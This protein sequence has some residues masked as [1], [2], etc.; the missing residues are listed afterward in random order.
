MKKIAIILLIILLI[1]LT[2]CTPKVT[3]PELLPESSVPGYYSALQTLPGGNAEVTGANLSG[4]DILRRQEDYVLTLS[5]TEGSVLED[6][7]GD[8]VSALPAYTLSVLSAPSRFVVELPGILAEN[9]AQELEP[10]GEFQ[11]YFYEKTD[12]GVTLYFQFT[13]GIV[14]KAEESADHLTLYVRASDEENAEHYHVKTIYRDENVDLGE[15]DFTPALCED[16]INLCRISPMLSSVEEADTVCKSV[17]ALLE[18]A[19]SDDTAEVILMDSGAAPDYTEPVSR[20]LLTMMGALKTNSGIIDGTMIGLN[21]RFVCLDQ[22]GSLLMACPQESISG[23]GEEE[24]VEELWLYAGTGKRSR[25]LDSLFASVQKAAVSPDGRTIAILEQTGGDRLLYLY[26]T[27][28]QGLT[29]L[30]AE[31]LGDYTADFC[32]GANGVLYIMC[33]DE[34]MQLMAFDPVVT[35]IEDALTAVEEREGGNG[36]VAVS[37]DSVYFNDEYGSVYA[38]STVDATRELYETADGFLLSPDGKQMLLISYDDAEVSNSVTLTLKSTETGEKTEIASGMAL[39]A[40]VFSGDSKALFM[41]DA[42]TGAD[43]EDYPVNLLKYNI[44]SGKMT[45]LG[46]LASNTIFPG[47]D[48]NSLILMFYQERGGN[49]FMPITYRLQIR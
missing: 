9:V 30:S 40:Y 41:L 14:F 47:K 1:T 39:S 43:S 6:K 21:A 48:E 3:E 49:V 33:G 35:P 25:L 7:S 36:N 19:G 46:A 29:F 15:Y 2:A 13:G 8:A 10:L 37:G 11:G 32:W 34:S 42:N 23:D 44:E 18:A 5:F 24:T 12:T 26:D 4:I 45:T 38:V 16:G 20:T 27:Q 31:G 17:N 22:N 28:N